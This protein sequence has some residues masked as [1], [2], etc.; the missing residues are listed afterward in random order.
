MNEEDE[1]GK[2]GTEGRADEWP[3]NPDRIC[4]TDPTERD[5]P[6]ALESTIVHGFSNGLLHY[7]PLHACSS[8]FNNQNPKIPLRTVVHLRRIGYTLRWL[9]GSV[10]ATRTGR[11]WR[12]FSRNESKDQDRDDPVEQIF[13][14]YSK[15]I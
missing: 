10:Y 6:V 7:S 2:E 11:I 8:F 5:S 1:G 15:Q 4:P 3:G 12:E 14:S 9:T 13:L